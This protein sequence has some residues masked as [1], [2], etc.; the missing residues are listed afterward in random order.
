[1]NLTWLEDFLALASSGNFSRAASE[2]HMTQ[3]AFSRRVRALEEWLGVALFDRSRHP[4]TLTETGQWFQSVAH[5]MLARAAR[6]PGDARAVSDASSATLRFASTHALSF[7]F[8]PAWLRGLESG[9]PVGAIQLVSDVM[10]QCEDLMLQAR[11]QFVL[12]HWHAQVPGRL[13]PANYRSVRVGGDTLV[14]VSAPGKTGKA[15]HLLSSGGKHVPILAYSNESG[16]GRIVRALRSGA[17]EKSRSEPVFTAHLA[18]V[19]K[20]M[21]LDGRGVAWLPLSLIAEE[22]A[23]GRLVAAGDAD[24]AIELDIRLFRSNEAAPPAAENFWRRV[25]G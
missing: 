4:V 18:S 1:M 16:L 6:I 22:L 15:R 19:L 13:D 25:T 11:V 21:A 10:Q 3:P 23:S 14:P 9:S 24:W 5:D 8:L 20:T 7:T 12:C 17:L 2:R